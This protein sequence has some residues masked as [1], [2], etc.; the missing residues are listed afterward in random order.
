[1]AS[2]NIGGFEERKLAPD[3]LASD[4][5]GQQQRICQGNVTAKFAAER[6]EGALGIR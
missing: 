6:T 1:M 3:L 5:E 2:P 4:K